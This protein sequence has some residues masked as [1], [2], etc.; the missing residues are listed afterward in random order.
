M[1]ALLQRL[2]R[3][4]YASPSITECIE[5]VGEDVYAA[6]VEGNTL[7]PLN[8][9]VVYL[10]ETVAEMQDRVVAHIRQ[11]GA[12][13]IAQVRDLLNASRKY[14]LALME[15]LDEQ[16]VTRRVGD[17]RVLRVRADAG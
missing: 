12:V 15:Y 13:T 10:S 14:S 1:D 11:Q 17:T 16:R 3:A 7:V 2:E 9:D 8:K 6:L 4:G 5:Q